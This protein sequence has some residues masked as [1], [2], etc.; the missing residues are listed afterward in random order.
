MLKIMILAASAS[1]IAPGPANSADVFMPRRNIAYA[2]YGDLDL[3]S[4]VGRRRLIRR[5]RFAADTVCTD[6]SE[7]VPFN[8]ARDECYRAAVA[9]AIDQMNAIVG[10]RSD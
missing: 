5:I 4:E 3:K 7:L 8:P 1:L 10:R 2:R 6:R 9:D